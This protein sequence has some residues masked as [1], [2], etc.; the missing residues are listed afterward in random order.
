MVKSDIDH[1]LRSYVGC[2][3]VIYYQIGLVQEFLCTLLPTTNSSRWLA[4]AEAQH[5]LRSDSHKVQK[6]KRMLDHLIHLATSFRPAPAYSLALAITRKTRVLT[7]PIAQCARG[8]DNLHYHNH[9]LVASSMG[10]GG[11]VSKISSEQ[12]AQDW[13][14]SPNA[15]IVTCVSKLLNVYLP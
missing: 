4:T 10:T 11:W 6:L 2:V 7:P 12:N 13:C 9:D 5:G 1:I 14:L 15:M 8:H 3:T